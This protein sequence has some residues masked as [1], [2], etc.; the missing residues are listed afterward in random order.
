MPFEGV[1]VFSATTVDRRERLGEEI[2]LWLRSHPELAPV[3]TEVLQSSDA[4]F[5][6]LTVV[7]FWKRV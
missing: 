6:C 7:V 3:A 2:T 4:R 1:R 5:H